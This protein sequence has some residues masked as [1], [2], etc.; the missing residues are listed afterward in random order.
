MALAR[1]VRSAL[2]RQDLSDLYQH[3]AQDAGLEVADAVLTRIAEALYRA[4]ERPLNYR[5]RTELNG[6]PRRI[7][8]FRFAI[9]FE[10]LPDGGIFVWRV[11]HSARDLRQILQRP[12]LPTDEDSQP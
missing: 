6:A 2:A 4:A 1:I 3:L 10:D 11:L 12:R 5:R 7:N 9:F 8:V